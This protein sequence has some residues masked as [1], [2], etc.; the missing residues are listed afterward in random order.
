MDNSI[1]A[2]DQ[3]VPGASSLTSLL[4]ASDPP[5]TD[6]PSVD[7]A[8]EGH[9]LAPGGQGDSQGSG[10]EQSSG[11]IVSSSLMPAGSSL[12]S[13]DN[14]SPVFA[15]TPNESVGLG[16][17]DAPANFVAGVPA[18]GSLPLTA[19]TS[20]PANTLTAALP[21]APTQD[22]VVQNFAPIL[23]DS[24]PTQS[25]SLVM[26]A[27]SITTGSTGTAA[28]ASL[29][30]FADVSRPATSALAPDPI[31]VPVPPRTPASDPI[32]TIVRQGS[33][34]SVDAPTEGTLRPALQPPSVIPPGTIPG[35]TPLFTPGNTIAQ[36]SAP[37]TPALAPT[38]PLSPNPI[39]LENQKPGTP[40]SQ[41]QLS[42]PGSTNIEGF[43]QISA[44]VGQTVNFKINTDSNHYRVD[45]YRL[46]YYG[47]NGARLVTTIDHQAAS[48]TNQPNPFSD[49]ATG[50]VDAGNWN[51]TELVERAIRRGLRRLPRQAHSRGRNGRCE[52]NSIRGTK[53]R[54]TQ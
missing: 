9:L 42:G 47:G 20:A 3:S 30:T 1:L 2:S 31:Q 48:G 5:S 19:N 40:Q 11:P 36:P 25:S 17:G 39:V 12:T 13:T 4:D 32:S 44:N 7:A 43:S 46:G 10:A 37:T 45:I 22:E 6:S 33:N 27:S 51:V 16:S 34:V 24:T 52:R 23:S 18:F 26:S 54:L 49:P 15:A 8:P 53:R 21:Q 50:E 38:A 35:S 14:T 29:S 41:W 28:D